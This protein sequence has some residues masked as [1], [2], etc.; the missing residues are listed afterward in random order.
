MLCVAASTARGQLERPRWIDQSNPV[1]GA[2]F[3]WMEH[4]MIHNG[5]IEVVTADKVN[6]SFLFQQKDVAEIDT[7]VNEIAGV[8]LGPEMPS[9]P[10]AECA[11]VWHGT[12]EG[13]PAMVKVWDL[14]N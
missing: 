6:R 9:E 8:T 7:W 12:I 11:G 4:H 14:G 3:Y 5:S 13:E 1:P 2:L 10:S